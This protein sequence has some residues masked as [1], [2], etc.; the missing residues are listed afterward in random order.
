MICAIFTKRQTNCECPEN[1][2][3][4]K[5]ATKVRVGKLCSN[6]ITE[7]SSNRISDLTFTKRPWNVDSYG[8]IVRSK[9][10]GLNIYKEKV[11]EQ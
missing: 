11:N 7:K 9:L 5:I 3:I 4:P 2:S 1:S 6:S 8:S 10:L